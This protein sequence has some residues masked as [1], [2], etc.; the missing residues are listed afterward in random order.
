MTPHEYLETFG[1]DP[2]QVRVAVA[3]IFGEIKANHGALQ[4]SVFLS[5]PTLI[6]AIRS[7]LL[8]RGW[9]IAQLV[10]APAKQLIFQL[11]LPLDPTSDAE[12]SETPC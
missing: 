1:E 2:E 3:T 7:A 12:F 6:P 8:G 11:E 4:G 9:R 5:D 10:A